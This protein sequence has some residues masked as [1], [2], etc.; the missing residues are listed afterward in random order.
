MINARLEL[1]K[2]YVVF[3]ALAVQVGETEFEDNCADV[4]AALE[5]D[6]T[7]LRRHNVPIEIPKKFI[8]DENLE[9]L[10]DAVR[11]LEPDELG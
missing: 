3:R 1:Y 9:L 10:K 5:R 4:M 6:V 7:F 2:Q 8:N 11:D